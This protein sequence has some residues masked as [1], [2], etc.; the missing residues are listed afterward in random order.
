MEMTKFVWKHSLN[1]KTTVLFGIKCILTNKWPLN[2]F[3]SS[4]TCSN[5]FESQF[6]GYM[7]FFFS[8][9]FLYVPYVYFYSSSQLCTLHLLTPNQP[10]ILN[11]NDSVVLAP[12]H[13]H[14]PKLEEHMARV[15]LES[16]CNLWD[17]PLCLGMYTQ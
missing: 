16:N 3:L 10:V 13:T 11:G 2:H 17:Q 15:G 8:F 9:S 7:F 6:I 14:Y 5:F 1:R 12:Y 4:W